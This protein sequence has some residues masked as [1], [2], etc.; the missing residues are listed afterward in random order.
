MR[1]LG[2]PVNSVVLEQA[3]RAPIERVWRACTEAAGLSAWQADQVEGTVSPGSELLLGWP[4]LGVAVE[5]GVERVEPL[6]RL[7]L[8]GADAQLELEFEPG[9]V[10]LCH[11]ADFDEDE[12]AGTLSSWKL[13][14]ATLAHYVERHAE[15][16]R[17]VHWLVERVHVSLEDAHAFFT[18]AGAH[19][20]W[21]TRSSQGT[22]IGDAG[23]A[24]ALDL[25]W[26]SPLTGHVLAHSAPRDA[27]ISWHETN[28]SLLALRTLP[29]PDSSER[30]LVG[31]WSSWGLEETAPTAAHLAGAFSRLARLLE[32]R[33]HA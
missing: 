33:V 6:K 7:V 2:K 24:V 5:L 30:L 16:P 1:A 25:A 32:R 8:R 3:T 21:L 27:L 17:V 4:A 15:Q 14:L 10:L 9:R 31:T 22:G 13:A 28:D 20:G 11:S 23:S 19:S 29:C 26:G 18:L 12:H